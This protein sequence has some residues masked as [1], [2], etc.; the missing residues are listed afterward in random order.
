[1]DSFINIV[2]P[3][4]PY[5]TR[6]KLFFVLVLLLIFSPISSLAC[7][8]LY[9]VDKETG[10]IYIANHEDYWYDTKAYI[11]IE[12]R[13]S[14]ELARLWY[15][16]DDFAQGGIN[17]DGLFFEGAVTPDQSETIKHYLPKGNL[18]DAILAN[19]SSVKEALAYLEDKNVALSNAHMMFGD[20]QGNAVV[21]EWVEG[22]REL[23]YINNNRLIMTNYLLSHPDKGNFPCQRYA[24]IESRL[25][26]LKDLESPL[27]LKDV[28]NTLGQA[29]QTPRKD[30]N[31]RIGGTLYSTF[32]R[33]STM[34]FFLVSKLDNSKVTKLNLENEFLKKKAQKIR[35][36]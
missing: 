25:N 33:L 9:Y 36:Y 35:L 13:S 1:M 7:S 8:V 27:S 30:K 6:I 29:A 20:N 24:S 23:I 2:H 32:I 31:N 12:P 21:V 15:G 18:G 16:W 11:Q 14:R 4:I 10:E 34:E 22:K 17:E 26:I 19:C 28:G 3:Y 5:Y